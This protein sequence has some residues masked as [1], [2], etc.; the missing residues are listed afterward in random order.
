MAPGSA[1]RNNRT[2]IVVQPMP[3][4]VEDEASAPAASEQSIRRPPPTDRRALHAARGGLPPAP[5][6]AGSGSG[7]TITE[8]SEKRRDRFM[9]RVGGWNCVRVAVCGLLILIVGLSVGLTSGLR[10]RYVDHL[11]CQEEIAMEMQICKILLHHCEHPGVAHPADT[12]TTTRNKSSDPPDPLP[13]TLFPAGSYTFTI[14]L[15]NVSTG[16][17]ADSSLFRCPPLTTYSSSHDGNH[18]MTFHWTI[19][20]LT[21]YSY[22]ISSGPD[23]PEP[24]F[25]NV[26]LAFIDA[27][28]YSERLVFNVTTSTEV[29]T[30]IS[31]LGAAT[32]R[33]NQTVVS[34]TLWTR[35][36]A[37]YPPGVSSLPTPLAASA[38][39]APWP[40]M[41]A[42]DEIQEGGV[43][44]PTCMD[45]DGKGI[46]G[47]KLGASGECGCHYANF[48]LD[49]PGGNATSRA[50]HD[51]K[52]ASPGSARAKKWAG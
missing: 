25:T 5:V 14:A 38:D 12:R 47:K 8:E 43:G 13:S 46:R 31:G 33:Y 1:M 2:S 42:V 19:T 41:V 32:C 6:P 28:Q 23:D 40:Y 26:T 37:S 4:I 50:D 52:V 51:E 44:V 20:P 3:V 17:T 36:P 10:N 9:K 49:A 45:G 18:P 22:A 35:I 11:R 48:G 7:Q 24:S 16:C 34:V 27:N 39:F 29:E 15:T 30:S 21:R